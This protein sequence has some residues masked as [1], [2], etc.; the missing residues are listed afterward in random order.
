[1]NIRQARKKIKSVGNVKKITKAM[2]LV[3]AIKMKKAQQF[4]VEG[5]PY[6]THLEA[7]IRKIVS[8]IDTRQS[9]LISRKSDISKKKNLAIVISSNKG[10]CGGFN[11]NLFRLILKSTDFKNTDFAIIGKKASLLGK[12]GGNIIADFSSNFPLENVSALFNLVLT[13]YLDNTYTN[14]YIYYNLFASTLRVDPIRETLLPINL[15]L[16]TQEKEEKIES[17]TE[18]LVEPSPEEIIDSLLKSFV[19]E[20]I[21]HAI[22]QSEAGE[23]SS[24]MIAMKNATENAN[25][26]IYNL[27]MLRNK[28]RQEK[29]TNELLD[30]ITAKESVEA[31]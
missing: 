15:L 21:R 16:D 2:Q 29:I 6:Q 1:M 14:I 18:Y 31:N 10:L 8:K 7:I 20:K 3:S 26:V 23:H 22:I 11:M 24:R 17:E 19:Q 12:F 4:A 5:R 13:K 27:T 30:M 25:D 28:L 9:E